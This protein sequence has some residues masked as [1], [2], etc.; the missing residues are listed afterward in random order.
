MCA[1]TLRRPRCAMPSTTWCAPSPPRARSPRRAS[2][3]ARR[4]PRSRT[5]S[6][7]GTR[8]ADSARRPR[9]RSAA[10]AG[11]LLLG[12]RA[13]AGSGPTRSPAAA[14]RAPRGRRCARSRRRSSRSRSRAAA[15]SASASVSPGTYEPQEPRRDPRLELRRQRRHPGAPARAPGRRAARSRAGRAARRDGRACGSAL[16]SA[17][18]AATPPSSTSSAGSAGGSRRRGDGGG[19]VSRRGA[20]PVG[21]QGLEEPHQPGM[22]GDELAVAALEQAS[23]LRRDGL[24][25]LEVLVE[26]RPCVA[27]VQSVD[28]NAL[29]VLVVAAASEER[30][31]RHHGNRHAEDET[32]RGGAHGDRVQPTPAPADR[33]RGQAEHRARTAR[34]P[35][36]GT[37]A[38]SKRGRSPR[39]TCTPRAFRQDRAGRARGRS[40]PCPS[41]RDAGAGPG[42]IGRRRTRQVQG[43]AGSCGE[44]SSPRGRALRVRTGRATSESPTRPRR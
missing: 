23:P 38:P 31:A 24:G 14:R 16:T 40:T 26:E 34:A 18:A 29:T 9:P 44:S 37:R 42:R 17:I 33:G 12:A 32:D 39:Q 35:A 22:G 25:V 5:A 6:G 28:I 8:G 19:A 43:E 41:G 13:A 27:G 20:V 21:L 2:G 4:G 7:R 3:R 10:R 1:S 15:G 11:A 30:A 36:V